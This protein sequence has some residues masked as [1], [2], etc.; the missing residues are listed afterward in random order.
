MTNR[1]DVLK[2]MAFAASGLLVPA[3]FT[4][5]P[6]KLISLGDPVRGTTD[7][8]GGEVIIDGRGGVTFQGCTFRRRLVLVGNGSLVTH[9]TIIGNSNIGIADGEDGVMQVYPSLE[10]YR[11]RSGA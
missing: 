10:G 1:R 11:S 5:E 2:G 4:G 3:M 8:I 7:D 6:K 9:C